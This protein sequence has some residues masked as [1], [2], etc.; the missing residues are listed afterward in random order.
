LNI[1][2]SLREGMTADEVYPDIDQFLKGMRDGIE[3][4]Q[5]R[6]SLE[7]A[8]EKI[9]AAFNAVLEA[10]NAEAMRKEAEYLEVN[11]KKPGV[12]TTPSGLQYEIMYERDGPKPAESDSVLVHYHAQF[13]DGSTFDSSHERG[14]PQNLDLNNVIEGWREG[15]QLMSIGS[16]F[17]FTIP[18]AIGYGEQGMINNWTGEVIIPPFATLIFEVE[19]LEINPVVE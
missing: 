14:Q 5:Q 7:E 1:G 3:G 18:S 19:L 2:A 12:V 4:R 10:K 16:K 6:F 13:T 11:A 8:R 9:E 17:V 15:L